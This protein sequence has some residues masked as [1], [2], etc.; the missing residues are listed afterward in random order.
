MI[1]GAVRIWL[2][3]NT[4]NSRASHLFFGFSG[5]AVLSFLAWNSPYIHEDAAFMLT[6]FNIF[7]VS[8]IFPLEGALVG[9]V[10]LLLIGNAV[11]WLWNFAASTLESIILGFFGA[12]LNVLFTIANPF[13]NLIWIVPFWSVSLTLLARSRKL[14]E[15]RL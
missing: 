7:F 12:Q 13:V 4:M 14:G 10:L 3:V 2:K 6:I 9:K 1:E 11:G 5:I 8:L 15:K